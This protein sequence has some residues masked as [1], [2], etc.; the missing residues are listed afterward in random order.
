M[1]GK[2]CC[3]IQHYPAPKHKFKRAVGIF[4]HIS[5]P[6][7]TTIKLKILHTTITKKKSFP[8]TQ[9]KCKI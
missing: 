1:N 4:K 2:T 5:D 9:T 3:N 6:I 7:A 8:E